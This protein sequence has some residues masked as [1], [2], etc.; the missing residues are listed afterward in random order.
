PVARGGKSTLDNLRLVCRGHNQ[1]AAE[2]A[3]G[4]GFMQ[5]KRSEAL[6]AQPPSFRD[7]VIRGLRTLGVGATEARLVVE[8][9]GA[10]Q[11]ATLEESMRA[12]LSCLGPRRRPS[13]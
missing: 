9:S 10:L 6:A 5:K 8:R 13:G 4:A 1:L 7:D 12:G 2:R 11:Q 3:L